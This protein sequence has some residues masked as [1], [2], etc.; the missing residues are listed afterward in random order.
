M[1]EST[2]GGVKFPDGT[3]QNSGWIDPSVA[4][5]RLTLTA[6]TP[7]TAAD[8]AGSTVIY[9]TPYNSDRIALYDGSN[10][11]IYSFPRSPCPSGP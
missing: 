5:G 1:I 9:Y 6:A 8:V 7:V 2:S 3:T 10:W 4:G 11:R